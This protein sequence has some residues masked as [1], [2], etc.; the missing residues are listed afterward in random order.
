MDMFSWLLLGHL[1][2]DWLLQNDWMAR[3]KRRGLITLAGMAHFITY[4]VMVLLMF[5]LFNKS[6]VNLLLALTVGTLVFVSHWLI[7]A[8]NLV[9]GWMRFYGQSDREMVRV[10]VDQTL[11]IL[12]LGLLTGCPC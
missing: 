9:Q 3:G 4:T 11:H 1:L 7:D 12:T 8:T 5:W 10:M 6:E 2:G